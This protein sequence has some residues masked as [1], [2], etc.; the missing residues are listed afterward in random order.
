MH[1]N[2]TILNTRSS[3]QA[4]ITQEVF[5][6]AGYPVIN[7][8]C[9]QIVATS[10]KDKSAGLLKNTEH[11]NV[12]IFTSQNAVIYAFKLYPNWRIDESCHVIAVGLKTAQCLEQ[13]IKNFIW[14]PQSQNSQGVIEL[15]QGLNKVPKITLI[16]A[17]NGRNLIQNYAR[18]NNIAL[19]QINVYQRIKPNVNKI[20]LLELEKTEKLIILA[21]SVTIVKNLISLLPKS[22]LKKVK[23]QT[24]LCASSRI[25]D[26]AKQQ[27][28]SNTKNCHSAN[29]ENMLKFLSI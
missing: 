11:Y 24:L 12:V 17:K 26:Y 18:D 13:Q 29:P 16:T 25:S 3:L 5:A 21:T 22:L 4:G 6:Q 20:K 23:G 28:F 1:K 8:P 15:L 9:L 10:D 19:Q 14:M 27:G 7:F 2:S